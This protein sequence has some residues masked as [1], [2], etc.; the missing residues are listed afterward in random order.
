MKDEKIP[1]T[2]IIEVIKLKR[3][4]LPNLWDPDEDVPE[5]DWDKLFEDSECNDFDGF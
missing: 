5:E 2:L 1:T 3:A 4:S